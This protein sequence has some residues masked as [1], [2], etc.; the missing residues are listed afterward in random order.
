MSILNNPF[1]LGFDELE[2]MLAQMTKTAEGFP[3]YNIEQVESDLLRITLAVAGYTESDLELTLE[4]NQLIIRG[5]QTPTVEH[6]YLHHGIAARS[7]IKTF[8]LAEGMVVEGSCLE[9]GLLNIDVRRP[10]K[11]THIQRIAI[12]TKPKTVLLEA[13][14]KKK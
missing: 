9:N 7:F 5:R 3:P 4:D 10:Q 13:G 8:V 1:L 6:H 11:Q 14:R 2:E 12:K